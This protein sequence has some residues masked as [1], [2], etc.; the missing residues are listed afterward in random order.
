MKRNTIALLVMLLLAGCNSESNH[1]VTEAQFSA[2][3]IAVT[4]SAAEQREETSAQKKSDT[5]TDEKI[6]N[7]VSE[8]K[9]KIIKN[10]SIQF[11]VK[12]VEASHRHIADFLKGNNAYFGSDNRTTSSYRLEN[13]MVIRVP[14]QNFDKLTEALMGES[15]YTD[16]LNI[17]AED[18]TDQFVDI[19][20]RLKT[21]KEVEQRY[22]ALLKEAKKISDILEVEEK[23]GGIREEIESA[24]GRLKLM[25][26]Q[27]NYSTISLTIY[28]SLDYVPEPQTGFFSKLQEAFVRG[29]RN[30]GSFVIGL[31]R[32][33]PFLLLFCLGI[34]LLLKL[35]SRRKNS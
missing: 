4:K 31:V 7:E 34:A 25:N 9:L 17:S 32:V 26:D 1:K 28:Q 29:W 3:D 10:A 6:L 35:R 15:I 18:V 22:L 16:Y 30:M 13:N 21:K 23:L 20:A 24:E 19:E 27:I 8:K 33:W 11:R 5:D 12:E 14:A 2:D